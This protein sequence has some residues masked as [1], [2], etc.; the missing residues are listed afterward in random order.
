[1]FPMVIC[2]LIKQKTCILSGTHVFLPL[3]KIEQLIRS[4]FAANVNIARIHNGGAANKYG[5][6]GF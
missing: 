5:R 6:F 4:K 3:K 2:V 1:M